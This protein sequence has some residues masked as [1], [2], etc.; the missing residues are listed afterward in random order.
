M[1][2]NKWFTIL[3]WRDIWSRSSEIRCLSYEIKVTQIVTTISLSR[4]HW[5]FIWKQR[6]SI[7][8][9]PFVFWGGGG[10]W[11]FRLGQIIYFHHVLGQKIYFRV[12]RG[13]RTEYLFST[14]NKFLKKPQNKKKKEKKRGV[15][16]WGFSRGGRTWFSMFCITFCRILARNIAI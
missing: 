15:V 16:V 2:R 14:C 4:N 10:G 7:R 3:Y 8:G 9:R 1:P 12:N 13:Q 6:D 11:H 5:M